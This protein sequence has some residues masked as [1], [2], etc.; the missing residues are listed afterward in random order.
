MISR[1]SFF[2]KG[3][4]KSTVK[5]YMWGSVLYFVLLFIIN[6]LNISMSYDRWMRYAERNQLDRFIE[7]PLILRS[8]YLG[9]SAVITAFVPT[10]TALL[11]FRYLHSKKT[12]VFTHSIPVKRS[13]NFISS[14]LAGLTLMA[15]PVIAN[16][17]ILM[18]MSVFG[19]GDFYTISTCFIWMGIL[20]FSIFILFACAV[21]SSVITGNSFAM[22]VLNVLVHSFLLM[23]VAGFINLASLFLYGFW[24]QNTIPNYLIE[25]NFFVTAI[26][27]ATSAIFRENF[28]AIK[29][30]EFTAISLIIY[31]LSLI[32]Y[33]KRKLENV[34]DVAGFKCLNHIFK[35][36]VTFAATICMFAILSSNIF[37]AP[38]SF[39]VTVVITSIV[40]Y[41][42]VE[43]VLKKTFNVF[44][45]SWKGY[46]AFAVCFIACVGLFSHTSFFGYETRIPDADKVEKVSI[47]NYYYTDE[48]PISDKDEIIQFALNTHSELISDGNIPSTNETDYDTRLHIKYHL[49]GGRE[50]YRIYPV[51]KEFRNEVMTYLYED[52]EYKKQCETV[53]IDANT[54]NEMTIHK[55][56]KDNEAG[57]VWNVEDGQIYSWHFKGLLEAIQK[58]V[59]QLDFIKLR[60]HD[61]KYFF[62]IGFEYDTGLPEDENMNVYKRR[63]GSVNITQYH[64]NTIKFL[65]E[66]GYISK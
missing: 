66:N 29:G 50:I 26:S 56:Y 55:H 54:V 41:F 17:I 32:L 65:E 1:A 39:V 28:T 52:V 25:N 48:E 24:D 2:N 36:A 47:F 9:I 18:A 11:I 51:S 30:F 23:L 15:L 62:N 8:D 38:V 61:D 10:I 21:F 3:V 4:Y 60:D 57:S 37:E 13:A 16:G 63:W 40:A 14:A 20:L 42:A 5:R 64:T 33:K 22:V 59:L 27:L 43:M 7:N 12:A 46:V 49:K 58:D 53:F 6:G 34:E 45:S 19:F 31:G 44:A 35:Y